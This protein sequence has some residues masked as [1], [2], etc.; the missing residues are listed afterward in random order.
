MRYQEVSITPE[1][2]MKMLE[3][4]TGN[5]PISDATVKQYASDM[6]EGRWLK[7]GNTISVAQDGRLLNGQQRLWAIVESGTTQDFLVVEEE[8]DQ[9]FSIFDIGRGRT[10]ASVLKMAGIQN[11]TLVR[12]V[13]QKYLMYR[14]SLNLDLP[15]DAPDDEK[16]NLKVPWQNAMVTKTEVN[17]YAINNNDSLQAIVTYGEKFIEEFRAGKV[18]YGSL[19]YIVLK[20]TT[21]HSDKWNEFSDAVLTGVDLAEG[22]PRLTLRRHTTRNPVPTSLWANQERVAQGIIAWNRWTKGKAVKLLRYSKNSLPMEK[23]N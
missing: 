19:A 6:K 8:N 12:G 14:K 4:N 20:H 21:Y 18:W 23:V 16:W 22:D 11:Q 7:S 1:I 15:E 13:A 5:R 3:N 17:Q 9:A 10:G 2:A